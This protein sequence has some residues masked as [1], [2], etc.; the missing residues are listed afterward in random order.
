MM[1]KYQQLICVH[2]LL[3]RVLSMHSHS[4][5]LNNVAYEE[6]ILHHL[7]VTAPVLAKWAGPS[8]TISSLNAI[9]YMLPH[10]S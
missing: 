1:V 8:M 2:K 3:L 4:V 6:Q 7:H 9:G 5:I 10:T